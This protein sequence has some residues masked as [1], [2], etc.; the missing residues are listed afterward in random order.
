M[1]DLTPIQNE[2]DRLKEDLQITKEINELCYD[3]FR[4]NYKHIL[5]DAVY[6]FSKNIRIISFR[7]PDANKEWSSDILKLCLIIIEKYDACVDGSIKS[8]DTGWIDLKYLR[9]LTK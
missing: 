1:K 4:E 2:I 9:I 5:E 8:K 6:D 3:E 7:F